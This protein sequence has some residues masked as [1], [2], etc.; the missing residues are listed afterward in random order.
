MRSLM[1]AGVL[2][3]GLAAPVFAKDKDP[4]FVESRAVKDKQTVTID[5]AKAYILLRTDMA[6]ALHLMKEPSPQD[7]VDYAAIR[8]T[9]L[10]EARVKY[11]KK[12]AAYDRAKASAAEARKNDPP[13]QVP[14]EPVE[15][16]EAN[17]EFT[18][19]GLLTGVPIGPMN[20]F[21]K[22]SGGASTYL[23]EVTPGTYRV[24]GPVTVPVG[25]A[26]VGTCFCMGSV[27]FEARAGEIADL[28]LV[29]MKDTLTA[30]KNGDTS[31]PT[32]MSDQGFF[33]SAPA[34]MALDPRLSAIPLRVAEYRPAGKLPNYFGVAVGRIPPIP[35]VLRYERD[36]IIDETRA[37]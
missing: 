1:I 37:E 20:R 3:L 18:P 2:A 4:V 31:A 16:T 13:V 10:A 23:H 17:F 19:F 9:A 6:L 26:A 32:T 25:A 14:E 36:R 34:T 21:A 5:P 12:R 35:N 8:A 29:F 7:S 33:R 28:G 22:A 15:P 27:R 24:Y 30:P 11:A